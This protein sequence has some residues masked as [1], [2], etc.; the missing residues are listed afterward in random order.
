MLVLF[1]KS[2][3]ITLKVFGYLNSIQMHSKSQVFAK[4]VG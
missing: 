2:G 1:C 4:Y 3:I